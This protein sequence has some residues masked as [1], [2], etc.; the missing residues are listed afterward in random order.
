MTRNTLSLNQ[1]VVLNPND[2]SSYWLPFTANQSFKKNPKL[3]AKAEGMYYTS[4]D[5]RQILDCTAGLWCVNA[6]HK[7]PLIVEAIKDQLDVMDYSPSFQISHPKAFELASRLCMMSPEGMDRVFFTNSGSESADTALKAALAYHRIKGEGHRT[8]LIGREKGYHGCNFGG[9][10]VGG[11]T[12]N[13]KYFASLVSGVDHL[14]N[15]YSV[16]ELEKNAFSK[17]QPEYGAEKADVL[18]DI[19]NLHDPS[20]IAAVIIE[21]IACGGGVYIP[22]KGYLQKL[23]AI[24]DKHSILLIFDEVITA[25]GRL[26]TNFAADYFGVTPDII[27]CAKGITNGTVPMGAVFFKTEIY[28]TF[29]S[30]PEGQI[31]F[32][33]GY[34][35][36]GHPLAV[37]ASL[38]TLDAY[39]EGD[40]FNKAKEISTYW[41]EAVHSL[42][43]LPHIIDIR[44]IGLIGAI[45]F[46]ADSK[47][48]YAK[49][50]FDEAFDKGCLIRF[51]G[52][53]IAMS[54]PLIIST[55]Q[56]DYIIDTLTKIIKS[57]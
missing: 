24:C 46:S 6:G 37:A 14:P 27:T 10:A 29:M 9:T 54:P 47:T 43:G 39:K 1:S 55:K 8:R 48:N 21:P 17:N 49:R 32:A 23:R 50:L 56:I 45:E 52:N 13:R 30:L 41:Q 4:V 19:C 36:S 20:T 38:G 12:G 57:F 33:H 25:F 3:L 51:T 2:L 7:H 35:Y 5:G 18:E 44:N 22:P 16:E 11:V 26:G 40:M 42:K 31:E 15:T 28:N 53:I 34:T